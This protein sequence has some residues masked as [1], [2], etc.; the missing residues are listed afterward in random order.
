V[1]NVKIDDVGALGVL[2][3][4]IGAMDVGAGCMCLVMVLLVGHQVGIV[5]VDGI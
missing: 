2:E 5:A 1:V 4:V 3:G